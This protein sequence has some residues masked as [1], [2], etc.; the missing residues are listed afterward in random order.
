MA[1]ETAPL[2]SHEIEK[3]TSGAKS[4]SRVSSLCS[5]FYRRFP[6]FPLLILSHLSTHACMTAPKAQEEVTATS[7]SNM[8]QKYVQ[9]IF[10]G[11]EQQHQFQITPA[12][13]SL[14]A[15]HTH[16]ASSLKAL[17]FHSPSSLSCYL[18]PPRPSPLPSSPSLADTHGA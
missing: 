17:L 4:Q 3:I 7:F 15:T 6:S 1:V 13:L 11:C 10:V 8:F 14:K 12:T 18:S 5:T 2:L 16:P 9:S